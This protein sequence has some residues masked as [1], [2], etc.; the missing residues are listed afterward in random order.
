MKKPTLEFA[1]GSRL[2][3]QRIDRAEAIECPI[4]VVELTIESLIGIVGENCGICACAGVE[5]RDCDAGF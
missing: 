5:C 4:C 1:L 3:I 2:H